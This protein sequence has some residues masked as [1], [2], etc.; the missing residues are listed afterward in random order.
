M[1]RIIGVTAPLHCQLIVDAS[2]DFDIP[3]WIDTNKDHALYKM[4]LRNV[5]RDFKGLSSDVQW[6]EWD[7]RL[8]LVDDQLMQ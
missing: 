2:Q 7:L 4:L 5:E 3:R 8:A 1:R 6:R